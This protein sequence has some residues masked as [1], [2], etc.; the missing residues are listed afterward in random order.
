MLS[1]SGPVCALA[2][3]G[4]ARFCGGD[5]VFDCVVVLAAAG[6]GV[7]GRAD[8]AVRRLFLLLLARNQGGLQVPAS[9][10]IA[11]A[12]GRLTGADG[13]VAGGPRLDLPSET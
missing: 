13:G 2:A 9:G 6:V 5:P 10:L 8:P 11:K 3:D 1:L 7:G 4:C 12:D